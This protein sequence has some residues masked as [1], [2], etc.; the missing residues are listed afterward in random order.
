MNKHDLM[1]KNWDYFGTYFMRLDTQMGSIDSYEACGT[2]IKICNRWQVENYIRYTELAQEAAKGKTT[3]LA[4][5]H[6]DFRI[7]DLRIIIHSI[8]YK[9]D[10]I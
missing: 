6:S 2:R 3:D 8:Y 1:K 7:M 9:V 10:F 4:R 5:F